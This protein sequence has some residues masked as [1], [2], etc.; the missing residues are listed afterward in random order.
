MPCGD[1]SGCCSCL[2]RFICITFEVTET[3]S[4]DTPCEA[5]DCS[6]REAQFTLDCNAGSPKYTGTIVCGDMSLDLDFR[7]QRDGDDDCVICLSST[8]LD[9]SCETGSITGADKMAVPWSDPADEFGPT[10]CCFDAEFTV[11]LSSV[12][13]SA[14]CETAKITTSAA[15]Y[16]TPNW[17][18]C[19]ECLSQCAC[20]CCRLCICVETI[21]RLDADNCVECRSCVQATYDPS[22]G[23]YGGWTA[24]LECLSEDGTETVTVE[25]NSNCELTISMSSYEVEDQSFGCPD[26]GVSV[27]LDETLE[28]EKTL[29]LS[30]AGCGQ[31]CDAVE[32]PGPCN[33]CAPLDE[34]MCQNPELTATISS[35]CAA[36][37]AVAT[38][39]SAGP[40]DCVEFN[41]VAEPDFCDVDAEPGCDDCA[42]AGWDLVLDCYADECNSAE[43]CHNSWVTLTWGNACCPEMSSGVLFPISCTCEPLQLVYELPEFTNACCSCSDETCVVRITITEASSSGGSGGSGG[44]GGDGGDGGDGGEGG[45]GG[46]PPP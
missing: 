33:C 39:T 4:S 22:I 29:I 13:G 36:L 17:G 18:P 9:L 25:L 23:D 20:L 16:V 3:T 19:S 6:K 14:T 46:P 7:L 24:D 11:D 10:C 34:I 44:E 40:G 27:V 38:L 28:A 15:S 43:P 21:D 30:C 32:A 35:D 5:C 26:V 1:D 41:T 42:L 12:A 31:D 37:N 8:A 45:E 2:P